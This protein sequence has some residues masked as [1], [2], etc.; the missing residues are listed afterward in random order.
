MMKRAAIRRLGTRAIN[1][2][3]NSVRALLVSEKEFKKILP[4]PGSEKDIVID[5]EDVL[6]SALS[7]ENKSVTR[8]CGRCFIDE[9]QPRICQCDPV[10]NFNLRIAVRY[11]DPCNKSI[12][13]C[14]FHKKPH[15]LGTIVRQ[16]H[17]DA[18]LATDGRRRPAESQCEL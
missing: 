4:L 17:Y 11:N 18:G 2:S 6:C 8:L 7:S 14:A 3:T 12:P 1:L 13:Q 16:K 15:V 5:R 9:R 10:S